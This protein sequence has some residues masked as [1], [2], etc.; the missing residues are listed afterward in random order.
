MLFDSTGLY[1]LTLLVIK[2]F[3][4][5]KKTKVFP[6][7]PDNEYTSTLNP[8]CAESGKEVKSAYRQQ[9]I[10]KHSS[11]GIRMNLQTTHFRTRIVLNNHPEKE[12]QHGS[13]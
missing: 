12:K 9:G 5:P 11:A 2:S 10:C 4:S 1:A 3:T 6:I 7:Y 8:L 13:Q